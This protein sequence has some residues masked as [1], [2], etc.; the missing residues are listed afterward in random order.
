MNPSWPFADPENVIALTLREVADGKS[1]I[2]L[3]THDADDGCWQ[4]HDGRD[5]PNPGDGVVV[6]LEEMYKLDP[7]IGEL[8]DLPLGWRA[9]REAPGEA[10]NREEMEPEED[11]E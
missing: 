2:V 5:N 4:F 9:W 8:A 7:S 1:P 6:C 11:E 10:W 3:V